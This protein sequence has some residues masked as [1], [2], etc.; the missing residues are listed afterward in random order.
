MIYQVITNK[1]DQII[2]A[3]KPG[4]IET[5]I[6]IGTIVA[7]ISALVIAVFGDYIKIR[8]KDSI[9]LTHA[10]ITTQSTD[11]NKVLL[12]FRIAVK[13]TGKKLIKGL[14][15]NIERIEE[16]NKGDIKAR[17]NFI[18]VPLNWTHYSDTRDIAIYET[19]LLDVVQH[20]SLENDYRICWAGGRLPFE[21]SISRLLLTEKYILYIS[22][23]SEKAVGTFRLHL[24]NSKF[25]II[26]NNPIK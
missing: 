9:K 11:N 5:L 24:E 12:I 10:K 22:F 14:R 6:A 26:D 25:E 15:C 17:S 7:V 13:N 18:P 16:I 20:V 3:L 4:I 19:A 2:L 1:L 23:Y 8:R 21:K